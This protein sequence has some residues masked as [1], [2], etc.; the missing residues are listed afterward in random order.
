MDIPLFIKGLRDQQ[1]RIDAA[2][3]ALEIIVANGASDGVLI[4]RGRGRP[5]KVALIPLVVEADED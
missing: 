2:I 3:S 4:K 5:G 1:G